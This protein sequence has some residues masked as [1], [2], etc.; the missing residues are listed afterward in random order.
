MPVS[1]SARP[2]SVDT[3]KTFANA[4]T[5]NQGGDADLVDSLASSPELF[6]TRE[7]VQVFRTRHTCHQRSPSATA[8]GSSIE[9]SRCSGW[10]GAGC[11]RR[12]AS[13][14]RPRR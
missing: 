7:A 6:Q 9:V 11:C 3:V 5:S 8:I 14:G 2:S 4:Q 10:P 13:I 1:P 12:I